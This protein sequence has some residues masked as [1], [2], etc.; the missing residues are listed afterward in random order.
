MGLFVTP[1][2]TL[3]FFALFVRRATETGAIT[4]SVLGLLTAAAVAFWNSSAG[5][6]MISFRYVL[7][8]SLAAGVTAGWI[9]SLLGEY[10]ND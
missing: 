4:G 3:F 5:S 2:F 9:V 7:P 10:L 8:A 1:L 6:S